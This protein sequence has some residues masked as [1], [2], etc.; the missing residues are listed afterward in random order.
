MPIINY[1]LPIRINRG[2]A[3]SRIAALI[4]IATLLLAAPIPLLDTTAAAASTALLAGLP[5]LLPANGFEFAAA[6]LLA[7]F[8]IMGFA[9]PAD[10]SLPRRTV[11]VLVATILVE[12]HIPILDSS[13][14]SAST[15]ILVRLAGLIPQS[16]SE[17][18]A[19]SP[20]PRHEDPVQHVE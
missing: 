6:L 14:I 10:G 19:R 12:V 7:C 8:L 1:S 15:A 11:I 16:A 20:P 5:M 4:L 2:V 9:R 3:A 13:A 18:A 17:V